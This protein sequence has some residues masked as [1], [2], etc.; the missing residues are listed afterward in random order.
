MLPALTLPPSLLALLVS[1]R[2]LVTAPSFRTSAPWPPGPRP[3]GAADGLRDAHR[4]F[5]HARWSAEDLGLAL[6]KLVAALL[7]PGGQPVTVAV[8]DTL[9]RRTGKQVHALGWFHDG[10]ATGPHQ[11]GPGNNGVIA[12][13]VVRLPF[14]TRPAALPVLARLVHRD[15][16]PAPASRPALARVLPGRQVHVVADAAYAGKELARPARCGDL[17]HPAAQGRRPVRPARP[18]HRQARPAPGQRPAPAIPG[19]PGA[20]GHF[21]PGDR[22]PLRP[23]RHRAGHRPHLPVARRLRRPPGPGDPGPRPR[24]HRL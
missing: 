1:F 22:A 7:V 10:S 23:H 2:P 6:A 18:A 24:C 16:K 20:N 17:D 4:F 19:P 3:A 15:L 11:V 21:R 5:S 12:A 9:V 13:I 8:D 14:L